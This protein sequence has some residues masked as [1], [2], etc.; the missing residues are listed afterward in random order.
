[1]PVSG[2]V[3]YGHVA[4]ASLRFQLLT[5]RMLIPGCG[6][7]ASPERTSD[8][9]AAIPTGLLHLL[10][11][12]LVQS[13]LAMPVFLTAGFFAIFSSRQRRRWFRLCTAS[14]AFC[15]VS[16]FVGVNV[17]CMTLW[18]A[19][20]CTQNL[21]TVWRQ[22]ALENLLTASGSIRSVV[23]CAHA[24]KY[25]GRRCSLCYDPFQP[26]LYASAV[27]CPALLRTRCAMSGAE[28][29]DAATRCGGDSGCEHHVCTA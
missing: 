15:T 3:L 17:T 2:L 8:G 13:L 10:I 19:Q 18:S 14:V 27:R 12:A 23:A 24:A 9:K 6:G 11:P 1:M 7:M 4:A 26:T 28:M 20:L 22:R 25:P 16:S 29:G 21:Q 5:Q